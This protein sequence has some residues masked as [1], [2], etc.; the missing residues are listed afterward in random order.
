MLLTL[1]ISTSRADD[2]FDRD[3]WF[4]TRIRPVLANKC[5]K[6]HGEA[7]QEGELR[8][9]S[10][11][12]MVAGGE[13]GAALVPGH[14]AESLL[15]EALNY[16]GLEMP[17]TGQLPA[18][19]IRDFEVWVSRDAPWPENDRLIRDEVTTILKSDEEW[20]A[21]QPL[22]L[23]EVPAD[24]SDS[25][26]RNPIDRFVYQRLRENDMVP[27]PRADRHALVRRIYFDL[28]G[29]PPTPEQVAAFVNSDS[30][31]LVANLVDELM[32]DPRYGEHWARYWLD[33]VRYS[34]S[35]GWNQDAY[36]PNIWQYRDYVVR[37]FNEDRPYPEFVREQLAGDEIS[38][39]NPLDLAATGF[40]RLGIYE[41][42]QRDAKSHWNDI[43]N[44]LTDVAGDVF[45]GMGMACARCH[46][47]K[48]DPVLQSDYF[49][50]RA[51]FEPLVWRDEMQLATQHELETHEQRM[52][53]WKNATADVRKKIDDL[54]KPYNDRKWA[55]TVD[56]F[57]LDI[58]ACFNKPIEERNSWE[59]QMAY[60]V[61]RQFLEEGGGP[62]KSLKAADKETYEKLQA[63]LAEFD[64]LKP[65][66]LPSL[67]TATDFAGPISPTIIPDLPSAAAV[68]PGFLTVMVQADR[69]KQREVVKSSTSS[70]R[71]TALAE[72]IGQPDNPLTT[73]V[74]VNRIWQEHFGTGIVPTAS[75]FGQ[76]GQ[77]PTHPA[78]LDWLA[79][80]FVEQGWS[81]K[82]L[83][84][85]ILTSA[86]WQQSAVHP[87]AESYQQ[88]DPAEKLI[89]R[90][91]VR[92]LKAEQIR[93]A[94]LAASGELDPTVGGESMG[95]DSKRRS[96]YVKSFRNTPDEMLHAFDIANGLKSV[97]ERDTTTTPAQSLMMING[98]FPLD[99]ARKMAQRVTADH[100][101]APAALVSAFQL[102]WG[103]A[104]TTQ[105]LATALEF[106]GPADVAGP[107]YRDRLV[108]F[109]HVLLNS[110][111][112]LYVE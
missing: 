12:A 16:D 28:I 5:L 1:L 99:Q 91:P 38:R 81:I 59:H 51:F 9:D 112:F 97:A 26:S 79:V 27:A 84:K 71:R 62:L 95:G 7:K 74:I 64:P 29:L 52:S 75:D 10:L 76:R 23:P 90:A 36:R 11:T 73:R 78:L 107:A 43:V 37:A 6:C 96:L 40:L 70:G 88:L 14:P 3:A 102:T 83:H 72:W 87:K 57:P 45:L 8:L 61:S 89:W 60:L 69:P 49:R 92:R 31:E 56:K 86:T 100:T 63:E 85:L 109:C 22:L 67:M 46:D 111:E 4:E 39:N 13:S 101:D 21:F 54:L 50:L 108:D 30:P 53:V 105:E 48:F 104:P 47:H 58:Q 20:W 25:W 41:Y 77:L 93:D 94:M 19:V 82:Q 18:S 98:D 35:D 110:N 34:E 32:S 103:R 33:I 55:S 24:S 15:I 66:P 2:G 44:E 17:P 106:V 68:E 65:D 42:N 80:T